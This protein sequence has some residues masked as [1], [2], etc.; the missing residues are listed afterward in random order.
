MVRHEDSGGDEWHGANRLTSSRCLGTPVVSWSSGRKPHATG[1]VPWE[2]CS[3]ILVPLDG[4]RL[5]LE[6]VLRQ[7]VVSSSTSLALVAAS[8]ALEAVAGIHSWPFSPLLPAGCYQVQQ[9][10]S[11][12]YAA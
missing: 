3:R 2:H 11:Q 10:L 8:C 6:F 7:Q 5:F 9:A 1:L 4:V 12:A